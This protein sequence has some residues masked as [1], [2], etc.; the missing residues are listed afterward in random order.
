MPAPIILCEIGY[1][2]RMVIYACRGGHDQMEILDHYV[3]KRRAMHDFTPISFLNYKEF[4]CFCPNTDYF[5]NY[6]L[7]SI[8]IDPAVA[9]NF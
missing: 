8:T 4:Q 6:W 7:S 9:V 5:L 3:M 1:N 2:Y